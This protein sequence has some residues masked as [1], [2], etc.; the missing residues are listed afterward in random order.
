MSVGA[1]YSN[2]MY[3][4]TYIHERGKRCTHAHAL[5]WAPVAPPPTDRKPSQKSKKNCSSPSSD[6]PPRPVPH[7]DAEAKVG[8]QEDGEGWDHVAPTSPSCCAKRGRGR[9]TAAAEKSPGPGREKGPAE[10]GRG[11]PGEGP[12]KKGHRKRPPREGRQARPR[13]ATGGP[14]QGPEGTMLRARVQEAYRAGGLL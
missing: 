13:G 14:A 3:P 1:L 12:P 9:G 4:H 7:A 8:T 2:L 11:R 5:F 6:G 10:R